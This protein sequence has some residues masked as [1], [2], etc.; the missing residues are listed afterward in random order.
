MSAGMK[1]VSTSN[2]RIYYVVC[3]VRNVL[4]LGV[5]RRYDCVRLLY[6]HSTS[7]FSTWHSVRLSII[8]VALALAVR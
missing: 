4:L 8:S 5:E 7:I 1:M 3:T 6:I 2:V